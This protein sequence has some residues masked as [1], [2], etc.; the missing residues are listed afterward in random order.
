M[1]ESKAISQTHRGLE[2]EARYFIFAFILSVLFVIVTW[3]WAAMVNPRLWTLWEGSRTEISRPIAASIVAHRRMYHVAP[4]ARSDAQRQQSS[5]ALL[6]RLLT[7]G[8]DNPPR[9]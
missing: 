6:L 7:L 3:R 4:L 2:A 5:K 1:M 9:R 8:I